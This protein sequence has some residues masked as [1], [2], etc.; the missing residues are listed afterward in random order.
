MSKVLPVLVLVAI[1]IYVLVTVAQADRESVRHI[2]KWLWFVIV[3]II[4]VVGIIAWYIFGRPLSPE[5]GGHRPQRPVA[6]D[7]DPDF[8]RGL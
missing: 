7:D 8:L 2:P 1:T 5:E 6:P 4:P 3:L